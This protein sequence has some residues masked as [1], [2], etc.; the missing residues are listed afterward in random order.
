MGNFNRDDRGGG[1]RG[2]SSRGGSG[3][4]GGRRDFGG[5]RG[6]GRNSDRPMFKAICSN[7]G[8][9]CEVPF[10]PTGAKPVFCSECFE[11]RSREAGHSNFQDRGP[12]PS[13]FEGRDANQPQPGELSAINA[14]LDKIL[15]MLAPSAPA[16]APKVEK[17][18]EVVKVVEEKPKKKAAKKKKA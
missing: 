9:E 12:R 17:V 10:R 2:F 16:L 6:F 4:G 11:K 14:K 1:G 7:C 8:K 13:N 18:E 15:A 3:F 5:G